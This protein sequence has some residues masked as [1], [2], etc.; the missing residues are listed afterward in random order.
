MLKYNII[1]CLT[2]SGYEAE[3]SS[4]PKGILTASKKCTPPAIRITNIATTTTT[5]T[6]KRNY[7]DFCK[8]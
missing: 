8:L 6:T 7:S 1:H 2:S 5:T 3:V 4:F